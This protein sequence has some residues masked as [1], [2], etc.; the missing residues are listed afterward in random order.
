MTLIE[1]L[2]A[3]SLL[4]I[5]TVMGYRAFANLLQ[6]REQL[7]ATGERWV[8]LARVLRRL[9]GELLRL[10]SSSAPG[11]PGAPALWLA[12]GEGG[13]QQ[14]RLQL[15][16]AAYPDGLAALSYD[17]ARGLDWRSAHVGSVAQSDSHRLLDPRY[18]VSWRVLA[19][20]GQWHGQWPP[21]GISSALPRALEM[22]VQMT[23]DETVRRL[24]LLP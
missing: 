4:S 7:M 21:S 9:E 2:I 1:L 18:H 15:F 6:A 13:G 14:L 5:L 12:P 8:Q 17:S 23:Q 24:W 16:S 19:S 22:Q 10:P 20:D 3:M 11:L